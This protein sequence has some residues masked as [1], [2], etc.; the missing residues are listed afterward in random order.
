M[1]RLHCLPDGTDYDIEPGETV[2]EAGLRQGIA[3]AHACGGRA[4]CS[5]CRIWILDGID[6]CVERN[7]AERA[8]S[9]PLGFRPEVRLACQTR[10]TGDVTFR[11]LVLDETDLE[12]ASQLSRT[13]MGKCGESKKIVVMFS[14]IRDFTGFSEPLSAYDVMFVL[15]RY[16]HQ[17]GD[18]IERNGGKIDN[19]I[20][21]AILAL[22]G[23]EGESDAPLR[24]VKA[25]LEMFDVVDK[26]KPYMNAMYGR[27]FDIGVGLHYGE[28]VIGHIG[29]PSREKLTA[30]GDTV[31]VASRIEAENKAAGTRLLI[32]EDLYTLVEDAVTVEDYVRVKLR[33]TSERK[34]LYEISGI[35]PSAIGEVHDA[36]RES[37]PR[38]RFAGLD[39]VRLLDEADLPP[40]SRRIVERAECDI[41][42][43]RTDNTI[44]AV[45]N[46]CPHLNLPF[47]DSPLTG[48][49]GIT[50]RWHE[51]CFDLDTGAIRAWGATLQADG[52]SEGM[53]GLGNV[54]KNR[55]PMVVFPARIADGGVWVALD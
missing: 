14:D 16:M 24:S 30:I 42:L 19:F 53:E 54:S 20:G 31:N 3:H 13:R 4:K 11:R 52:T 1:S 5:T 45:N 35:S 26:F 15:N 36:G 39:W 22:F 51:S 23:T 2:L 46:A 17:M 49:G 18:V 33:G 25:A 10:V 21:D 6:D 12:I 44:H 47:N 38:Q 27:A 55:K 34:T 41:L 48:D 43:I 9:D 29:S 40:G 32:S 50:C 28:A 7:A 8:L 37:E